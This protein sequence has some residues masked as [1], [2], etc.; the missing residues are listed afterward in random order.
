MNLSG[1]LCKLVHSNADRFQDIDRVPFSVTV[2]VHDLFDI[3]QVDEP[4]GAGGARQVG[5]EDQLFRLAWCV[6]VDHGVFFRMQAAAVAGFFPV[7]GVRQAGRIA[8]VSHRE[9]FS[10]VGG[11]DHGANAEAGTGRAPGDG[12]RELHIHLIEGGAIHYFSH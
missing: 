1:I 2:S 3:A 12:L 11:G 8:V 7:T 10:V 6:A 4:L 9:D 5:D